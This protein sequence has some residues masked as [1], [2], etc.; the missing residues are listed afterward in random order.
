MRH[1]LLICCLLFPALVRADDPVVAHYGAEEIQRSQ[2]GEDRE[3]AAGEKL[4]ELVLERALGDYLKAHREQWWPG[5]AEMERA[6]A[7]Y[8]HA[9]ACLPYE[10][11]PEEPET[12]RF[13]ATYLIAQQMAQ[14]W[15][16][17]EFGGGRLLFQQAGIEAFDATHA[18]LRKLEADE[19]FQIHDPALRAAAYDYWTRDQ[20]G[21]I[22]ESEA[23]RALDPEQVFVSCNDGPA[24][25]GD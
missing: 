3:E 7:A 9:R 10:L 5:E 13:V 11:P 25:T 15:L 21:L 1:W 18:L 16:W 17:R 20:H 19:V 4:R 12:E 14:R 8:R 23:E 24:T 6:I 2:L 22:V